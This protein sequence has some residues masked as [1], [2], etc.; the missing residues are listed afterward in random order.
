MIKIQRIY[1]LKETD[2]GYKIFID[3]LW[4]RGISKEKAI[5]D[6]W[7]KEISPSEE[8][9][10]WFNHD[11]DKWEQFK[12]QYKSELSLKY[13]S[14]LKLKQLE[15]T[16]GSLVLLYAAKDEIHNNACVLRDFL[17]AM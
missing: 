15:Q 13:D 1:A 5:W 8:L 4:P 11:P 3:R 9:R 6:E 12:Q 14:L 7:V 17:M 10:K 16:Y 2:T